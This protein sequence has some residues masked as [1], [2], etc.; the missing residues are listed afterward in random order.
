[1]Y[2][3]SKFFFKSPDLQKAYNLMRV[4]RRT[5]GTVIQFVTGHAFLKR[6]EDVVNANSDEHDTS[7]RLCNQ[8]EETPFHLVM[9]CEELFP[10]RRKL[11]RNQPDRSSDP[12]CTIRWNARALVQFINLNDVSNLLTPPDDEMDTE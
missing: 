1:M 9:E 6:H 10:A 11:F 12:N 3:Q 7:C 2:R 8:G 4:D 5:L